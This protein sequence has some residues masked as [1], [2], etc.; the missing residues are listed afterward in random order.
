M[1]SCGKDDVRKEKY[2]GKDFLTVQESI[3]FE[4][5]GDDGGERINSL[6]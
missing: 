6:E 4:M 3:L 5:G 1:L 2:Q